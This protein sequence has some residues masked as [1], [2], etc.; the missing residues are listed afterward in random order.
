MLNPF[1]WPR[2]ILTLIGLVVVV[3]IALIVVYFTVI[4][5]DAPPPVTIESAVES[6]EDQQ[7]EQ[8]QQAEPA[9]PAAEQASEDEQQAV[10]VSDADYGSA[11]DGDSGEDEEDSPPAEADESDDAE[12]SEGAD[13]AE[14]EQADGEAGAALTLADLA[15]AWTLAE[16]GES[17]VGYRIGE[18]F[19]DIGTA[20]AVGRTSDLSAELDFDGAMITRVVIV[21]DLRTL[22]SD[23]SRR[24]QA[25]RSRGLE[26]DTYPTATFTLS[27][28][29]AIGEA[30]LAGGLIEQSV[31]GTLELHG[32]ANEVEIALTGQ[33]VDGLAV[34]VG[35]AEIALADY[36]IVPPTNFRVISIED[37]GTMEFQII[38]ARR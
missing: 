3:I 30:A 15:G 23:Q 28:P 12:Q 21:A 37:S 29:I 25:L 13:G 20:T 35:S 31:R 6:L 10:S 34:I 22:R 24:D 38:L 1:S 36:E 19:A 4:R 2:R 33:L 27:E 26:T 8:Q 9:A 7:Q 5:S 18:T 14:E 16:D 17:F 32:V 11:Q